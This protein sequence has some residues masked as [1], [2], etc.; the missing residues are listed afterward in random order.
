V[1]GLVQPGVPA[2]IEYRPQP[3]VNAKAGKSRANFIVE[4]QL[5]EYH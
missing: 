4:V 2:T 5:I 1:T 3:Y